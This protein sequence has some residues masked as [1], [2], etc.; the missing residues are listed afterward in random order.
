MKV[1]KWMRMKMGERVYLRSRFG[2]LGLGLN[3]GLG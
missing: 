3:L 2:S 1:W